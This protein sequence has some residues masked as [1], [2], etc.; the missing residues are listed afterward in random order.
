[1]RKRG[2]IPTLSA[3]HSSPA[4]CAGT[5]KPSR[6]RGRTPGRGS[7]IQRRGQDAV[8]TQGS[9]R[10]ERIG[11]WCGLVGV[12]LISVGFFAID[13]GGNTAPDGPAGILVRE[14][15]GSRAR[16]TVVRLG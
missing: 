10:G 12:V 13:E 4:A 11:W 5:R 6:S 3:T 9:E 16:L 15:V 14:I 8:L 1:M 7:Q 2:L